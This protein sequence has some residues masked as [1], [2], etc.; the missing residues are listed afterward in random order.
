MTRMVIDR[1]DLIATK[2]G[3]KSLKFFNRKKEEMILTDADLLKEVVGE[4]TILDD[5][6]FDS[7]PPLIFEGTEGDSNEELEVD[8]GISSEEIAALL[9]DAGIQ[10]ANSENK[11]TPLAQVKEDE[12]ESEDDNGNENFLYNQG[13]SSGSDSGEGDAPLLVSEPELCST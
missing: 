3:Y 5:E 4:N 2:Q 11:I 12:Q 6:D 13:S 7:L 8:E 1:V 9:D 10:V